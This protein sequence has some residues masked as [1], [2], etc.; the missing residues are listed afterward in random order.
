[1]KKIYHKM[2]D[3][4]NVDNFSVW[5]FLLVDFQEKRTDFWFE[6]KN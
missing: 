5:L 2:C 6:K 4:A 1:M 3:K